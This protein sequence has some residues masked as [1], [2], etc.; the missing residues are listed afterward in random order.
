[1]STSVKKVFYITFSMQFEDW[2]FGVDIGFRRGYRLSA[3]RSAQRVALGVPFGSWTQIPRSA[4]RAVR[5]PD[6]RRRP[7]IT[8]KK[9]SR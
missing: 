2:P 6:G 3:W 5:V 7:K 8:M 4:D 9:G 1:M